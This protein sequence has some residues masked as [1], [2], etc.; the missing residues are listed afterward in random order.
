MHKSLFLIS[1]SLFFLSCSDDEASTPSSDF[2]TYNNSFYSITDGL[3]VDFG[4][5]RSNYLSHYNYDLYLT[6]GE[7]FTDESSRVFGNFSYIFY[8]ELYS[9]GADNFDEGV[10]TYMDAETVTA[11]SIDG[12]NWFSLVLL[13]TDAGYEPLAEGISSGTIDVQKSGDSFVLEI[14][15]EL[16]D[17][18]KLTAKYD[19]LL[20]RSIY[21]Q[22]TD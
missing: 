13:S 7:A 18:T 15:I 8:V 1:L 10:F 17:G 12:M 2:L 9:S 5:E 21:L 11:E 14:D 20:Q 3:Y 16:K 6:D 22:K 4:T 19:G